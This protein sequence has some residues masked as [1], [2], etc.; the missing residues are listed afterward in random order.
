MWARRSFP[1]NKDGRGRAIQSCA[2]VQRQRRRKQVP[3]R[4]KREANGDRCRKTYRYPAAEITCKFKVYKRSGRVA[5]RSQR[6]LLD[7]G[8]TF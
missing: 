3:G 4:A 8:G 7:V 2:A 5:R 6:D 1:A